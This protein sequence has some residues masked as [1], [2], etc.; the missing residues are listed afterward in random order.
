MSPASQASGSGNYHLLLFSS[1][2]V[3]R[4]FD[5]GHVP[6]SKC[7]VTGMCFAREKKNNLPHFQNQ[8]YIDT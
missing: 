7:P 4:I 1:Y 5:P 2:F 6:R 3:Q 8:R